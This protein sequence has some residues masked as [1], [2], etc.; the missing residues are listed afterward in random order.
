MLCLQVT[1]LSLE[2]KSDELIVMDSGLTESRSTE[3]AR[4]T[5]QLAAPKYFISS[6][7]KMFIQFISDGSVSGSGFSFSYRQSMNLQSIM[8]V[9]YI[10]PLKIS[11]Y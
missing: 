9:V 5:G 3:I 1:F 2:G 6:D 11:L 4:L 10:M 7:N 8:Y